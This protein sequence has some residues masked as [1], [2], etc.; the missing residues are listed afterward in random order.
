MMMQSCNAIKIYSISE[1]CNLLLALLTT[2]RPPE[3][4]L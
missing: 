3:K 1:A 2:V 4:L